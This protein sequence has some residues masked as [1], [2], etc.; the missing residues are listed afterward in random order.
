VDSSGRRFPDSQDIH[1]TLAWSVGGVVSTT[2]DLLIWFKALFD[3][4]S[5]VLSPALILRTPA[6]IPGSR[7]IRKWPARSAIDPTCA[8]EVSVRL[9][10]RSA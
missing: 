10:K 3:A 6:E 4:Q 8:A 2:G 9:T 5:K 7:V 1:P